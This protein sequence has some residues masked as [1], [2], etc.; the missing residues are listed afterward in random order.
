MSSGQFLLSGLTGEEK[1]TLRSLHTLSK[2][3]EHNKNQN[4]RTVKHQIYIY[5]HI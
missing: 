5:I 2:N 3:Q 4:T 1:I